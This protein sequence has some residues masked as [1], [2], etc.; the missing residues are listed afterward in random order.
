MIVMTGTAHLKIA[1]LL[2]CALMLGRCSSDP[3]KKL[4]LAIEK[5]LSKGAGAAPALANEFIQNISI[6]S[7]ETA[8]LLANGNILYTP[9]DNKI[10]V[11]YPVKRK[12]AILDGGPVKHAY[13]SKD[14]CV[15]TDEIQLCI[16]DGD[17]NHIHDDVI[18]ESKHL[19]RSILITGDNIIYYKDEKLYLYNIP[20]N[21][22]EL[23]IREAFPSPFTPYYMANLVK[24]DSLLG[25]L[26]GMAGSYYLSIIN[27]ASK[28]I[29]AKNIALASS[30]FHIGAT[31]IYYIAGNAGNW[32]LIQYHIDQKKKKSIVK[33]ND[34]ADI[35]LFPKC[36]IYESKDGLWAAEYGTGKSRVPF[37]YQLSGKYRGRPVLKY[38]DSYYLV[39]SDKL[40]ASLMKLKD[41][42]PGLFT[43]YGE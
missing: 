6:D 43:G 9:N 2:I 7:L 8:K 5:Y 10:E 14:Y 32:E 42:A 19:I 38:N 20:L 24:T 27:L 33:F 41:R 39:N 40:F 18:G 22:S 13:V 36:Y 11:L 16:F 28:S 31:H 25:V 23:L 15:I 17:G 12:L 35:E 4:D 1:G 29:V 26:A 21:T 3:D 37:P 30:K 34:I